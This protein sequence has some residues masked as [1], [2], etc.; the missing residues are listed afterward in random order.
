MNILCCGAHPDD[1]EMM[2]GGVIY[3]SKKNGSLV[4]G[5]VFTDGSWMNPKG[6]RVRN[7]NESI[8]EIKEVSKFLGYE[9]IIQ[10]NQALN[11]TFSDELVVSVLKVIEERKIDLLILPWYKDLHPDHKIVSQIGIAA[12][13]KVSKVLFGQ[14]NYHL[15]DFF[16][17]NIFI[18]ITDSFN[19]KIKALSMYK[20]VWKNNSRDWL[21]FITST[22]TYYGKIVGVGK[23]EGFITKK[24]LF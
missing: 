24:F 17:P 23:A 14:I 3:N 20:S 12:S 7:S 2:A 22:N 6:V 1:I 15:E 8:E 16:T 5:M 9:L 21:D 18:D 13:R 19:E 10:N 11:M 4:I